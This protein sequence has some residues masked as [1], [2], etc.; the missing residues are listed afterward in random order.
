[1]LSFN[2]PRPVNSNKPVAALVQEQADDKVLHMSVSDGPA[3]VPVSSAAPAL[4]LSELHFFVRYTLG[5]Y[6]SFM[7]EHGGF[8]IRRR[9]IRFPASLYLRLKSTLSAALHF[10]MLGR[11]RRTYEFTID[12]HGIV[13][14]SGGVTLIGWEDV[15]AVRTYTR[16]FMMVLKRGTLPLPFRALSEAQTGAMRELAAARRDALL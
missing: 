9:R 16:G 12:Q 15:I 10:I 6:L 14:T 7:W 4:P 8:L 5:E 3:D 13:R 11:G 1:M 2:H